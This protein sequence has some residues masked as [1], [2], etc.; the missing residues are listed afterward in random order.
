MG[1][2]RQAYYKRNRAYD[3]RVDGDQKVVDFVLGKRRRQPR[4]GTRKLHYLLHDSAIYCWMEYLSI[5]SAVFR[6][7]CFAPDSSGGGGYGRRSRRSSVL[8]QSIN[9]SAH[10]CQS[11]H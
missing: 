2:S 4:L 5:Q 3:A 8:G 6:R 1:I 9:W 11:T 7:E 10:P